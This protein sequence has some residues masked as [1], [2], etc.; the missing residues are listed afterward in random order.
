[1]SQQ[2]FKKDLFY[3][4]IVIFL[5]NVATNVCNSTEMCNCKKRKLFG[6]SRQ[7]RTPSEVAH[8]IRTLSIMGCT[9]LGGHIHTCYLV[10]FLHGLNSS[11]ESNGLCTHFPG[12]P[13]LENSHSR[14]SSS[15]INLWCEWTLRFVKWLRAYGVDFCITTD[16]M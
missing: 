7:C 2:K 4:F 1:M 3:L 5:I 11:I 16:C 6:M 10:N 15:L 14:S 8:V 12:L 13:G 9:V